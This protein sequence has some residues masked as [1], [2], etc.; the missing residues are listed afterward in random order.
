MWRRTPNLPLGSF[1]GIK[2]LAG[3]SKRNGGGRSLASPVTNLPSA[4]P[5]FRQHRS[6]PQDTRADHIA[7]SSPETATSVLGA[8][9][10]YSPDP[11]TGEG[12]SGSNRMARWAAV[13][14]KQQFS[15]SA[16]LREATMKVVDRWP[17]GGSCRPARRSTEPAAEG[18]GPE[19]CGSSRVVGPTQSRGENHNG[20]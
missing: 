13:C 12:K 6:R 20:G 17:P 5:L 8:H 1:H 10:P 3:P 7:L 16:G 19:A 14:P 9:L 11:L 4:S 15:K 18:S 2:S